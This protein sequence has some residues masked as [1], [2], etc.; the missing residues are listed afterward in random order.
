MLIDY[1]LFLFSGVAELDPNSKDQPY[2]TGTDIPG[3]ASRVNRPLEFLG[4]Y[5]TQH[6]ASHRHD[7][8]ALK[9]IIIMILLYW[10]DRDLERCLRYSSCTLEM[11][12][13][14]PGGEIK[15]V[16]VVE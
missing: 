12:G 6:G 10:T 14:I 13:S 4:L 1:D 16:I 3:L 15:I 9:V 5:A 2:L 7:I 8:P 11:P